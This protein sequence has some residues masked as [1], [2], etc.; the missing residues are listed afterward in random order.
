MSIPW[1][2]TSCGTPY[3]DDAL[4]YR[5]PKCGGV[6]DRAEIPAF[7]LEA[8]DDA[9]PGIWRYRQ[10]FALPPE[11]PP[12]SLGEGRTPLVW[13]EAFGRRVAFKLEFI[14]PTGSHKD[15]GAA[16]M[17]AFLKSRG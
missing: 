9:L 10:T 11:T 13:D 6:F 14:N 12:V 1:R 8:V 2:C 17:A 16:L 5:C 7:R 15:R 3:P 4:P